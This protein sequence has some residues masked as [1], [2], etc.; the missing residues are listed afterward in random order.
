MKE[1]GNLLQTNNCQASNYGTLPAPNQLMG[2]K[3]I[4]EMLGISTSA[5]TNYQSRY[6]DFPK[7][8]TVLAATPVFIAQNIIEWAE[9]HCRNYKAPTINKAEWGT[10]KTIAY[11]GRPRVG[12]SFCISVFLQNAIEYRKVASKPGDDC[13]QCPVIHYIKDGIQE[14]FAVFHNKRKDSKIQDPDG[15]D[16]IQTP[17][18]A[19]KFSVFMSEISGYLKQ[20]QLSNGADE[21]P[22]E[23]ESYIEIFMRPSEMAKQIMMQTHVS[24]LVVIDTPGVAEEYGMVPIE[25]ADLVVLVAADSNRREAQKSYEEIVSKMK[26]LLSTSRFCF[27]YRTGSDGDD[28]E[29]YMDCQELAKEA[30]KSFEENFS[31]LRQSNIIIESEMEVLQPAKAVIGIPNMGRLKIKSAEKFFVK[32]IVD[33]FSKYLQMESIDFESVRKEILQARNNGLSLCEVES[34]LNKLLGKWTY[35]SLNQEHNG[36]C[37]FTLESFKEEKHGRVMTDDNYRLLKNANTARRMQLNELYEHFAKYTCDLYT[38]AWKQVVIKYVY[39]Q[40]TNIIKTDLGILV[41]YHPWEAYP[42]VTM[43]AIESILAEKIL[44]CIQNGVI[45]LSAAINCM[46]SYGVSSLS[47]NYVNVNRN[48]VANRAYVKLQLIYIFKLNQI[49]AY[50]CYDMV[51]YRYTL[52]LQILGEYEVFKNILSLFDSSLNVIEEMENALMR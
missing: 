40:I 51:Y 38:D 39:A 22:D 2:T 4:A 43:Y 27:L 31:G 24:A 15:M 20:K 44:K 11:V 47:W 36:R 16:G 10:A 45:S 14:E 41:G 5:V 28:L 30:M 23:S 7:P 49:K 46:M 21:K 18:I 29:E 1:I 25:K 35:N 50:S 26:P 37:E 13:T 32:D 17:I 42:P 52:G 8:Y 33:K 19:E 48:D 9:K 3:E 12:K 6:D 34:F